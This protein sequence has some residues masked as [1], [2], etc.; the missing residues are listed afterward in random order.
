MSLSLRNKICA[1][2]SIFAKIV[3]VLN[4]LGKINLILR[5]FRKGLMNRVDECAPI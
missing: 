5:F 1:S 2:N 3:S 4:T